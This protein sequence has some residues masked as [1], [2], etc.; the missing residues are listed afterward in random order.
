MLPLPAASYETCEKTTARVSSLSL[1]RYRGSDD[2]VPTQYGHRQVLV[3]GYVHQLCYAA[4][5]GNEKL[6]AIDGTDRRGQ[7]KRYQ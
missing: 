3:K 2:S 5:P 6:L 1:V 7:I 4:Q